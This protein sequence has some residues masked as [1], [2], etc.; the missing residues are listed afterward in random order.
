M[1]ISM[2]HVHFF[3][4]WLYCQAKD[5]FQAKPDNKIDWLIDWL[6]SLEVAANKRGGRPWRH[7][8][9]AGPS[10][11]Q[12]RRAPS[13]SLNYRHHWNSP[14]YQ[15]VQV[16]RS[17][18]SLRFPPSSSRSPKRRYVAL[19]LVPGIGPV[20]PISL[21]VLWSFSSPMLGIYVQPALKNS[22][23]KRGSGSLKYV[24]NLFCI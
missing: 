11:R 15:V 3:N 18:V 7:P 19:P 12:C 5:K 10:N 9:S 17:S 14:C 22:L 1:H 2:Y 6:N 20:L 8:Q 4:L 13:I 23:T 24:C 16:H 21:L